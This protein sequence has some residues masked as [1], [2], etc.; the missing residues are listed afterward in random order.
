MQS[1]VKKALRD[2]GV[3]KTWKLWSYIRYGEVDRKK[4]LAS[5]AAA[6]KA[7][8]TADAEKARE[9]AAE[10]KKIQK[11]R[12]YFDTH[13]LVAALIATVTFT[14]GFTLPGGFDGNEG[15]KQGMAILSRKAAF[16][17]FM[18]TDAIGLLLSVT[19]LILYFVA[20][21]HKDPKKIRDLVAVAAMLNIAAIVAMMLAFITGTFAVLTQSSALAISVC[22]IGCSFFLILFIVLKRYTSDP[23]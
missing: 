16:K 13:M 4:I 9:R 2:T 10:E 14:S 1:N 6:E 18:V 20:A 3:K 8:K 23:A 22:L 11:M 19:S 21:M 12:I 5:K 7:K 17:V 15:P